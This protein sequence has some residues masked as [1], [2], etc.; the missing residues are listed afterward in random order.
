MKKQII[1][2]VGAFTL[3]MAALTNTASATSVK[4][5]KGDTLWTLSQ[6]HNAS[7]ESIKKLNNLHSTLIYAGST[8]EIEKGKS[9]GASVYIIKIGDNLNS[10]SQKTGIPVKKLISYNHLSSDLI[11]AGSTLALTNKNQKI[12]PE[13]KPVVKK[14]VTKTTPVS[15][16]VEKVEP[17][18]VEATPAPT[19]SKTMTMKATA[20]TAECTGCSGI[21]ATGID[22]RNST[23][24][25]IAVDPRVIPLGSKVWV[26]GYGEAIAGDTGGAIKG[27]RV[28]LLVASHGEAMQYGVH[29]VQVKVLN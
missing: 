13:K 9:K 28:D 24:K 18:Q 29:T 25:L 26:E 16:P 22:V 5:E 17:K 10:I 8:L 21:T 12:I 15:N 4:V 2:M 11:I 6:K 14:P 27:N 23:P 19:S 3:M 7:V 20:Y 1:A